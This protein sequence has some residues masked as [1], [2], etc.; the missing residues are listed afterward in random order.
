M[1]ENSISSARSNFNLQFLNRLLK[2]N[3]NETNERIF[4]DVFQSSVSEAAFETAV[5]LVLPSLKKIST[6]QS[7]L[8]KLLLKPNIKMPSGLQ[9]LGHFNLQFLNSLLKLSTYHL[10]TNFNVTFQ[11][12]VSESAFETL[13]V[14]GKGYTCLNPFQSSVSESAFE[15]CLKCYTYEPHLHPFQSSVS[16]LAFETIRRSLGN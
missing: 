9:Q 4:W 10:E 6:S 2:Q 15:T 16:E 14:F 7:S 8:L 11:S 5:I 1:L 12:S 3:F 13:E